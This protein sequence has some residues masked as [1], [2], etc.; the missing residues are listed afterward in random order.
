LFFGETNL[1]HSDART[2]FFKNLIW[3]RLYLKE[4]IH[5]KNQIKYFFDNA[6]EKGYPQALHHWDELNEVVRRARDSKTGKHEEPMIL[7]IMKDATPMLDEMK[8]K[9]RLKIF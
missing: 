4:A 3:T 8:A 1:P 9:A 5:H 7:E 6:R 2:Y